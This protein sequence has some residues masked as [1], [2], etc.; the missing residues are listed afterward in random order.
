ME[1]TPPTSRFPRMSGFELW[2]QGRIVDHPVFPG[3]QDPAA[4][5]IDTE[6]DVLDVIELL[7]L[8]YDR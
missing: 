3:K 6:A 8:N 4:R 5:K 7:R 1:I 2:N